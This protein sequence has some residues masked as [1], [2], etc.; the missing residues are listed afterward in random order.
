M[1]IGLAR[2][3]NLRLPANFDSPYRAHNIIDF[4][5]RWH[6]TLSRF[7]RNYLYIP[8]GGNRRGAIRQYVNLMVTMLLGGLWHG[9]GWGFILWGGLNGLYLVANHGFRHLR[10]APASNAPEGP[11]W[12]RELSRTFTFLC[13]LMSW[14]LFRSPNFERAG[15]VFRGLLGQGGTQFL[16]GL[17]AEWKMALLALTML[18]VC[19]YAPNTQQI[20]KPYEPVF[21]AVRAGATPLSFR[22]LTRWAVAFAGIALVVLT[23]LTRVSEF[24]YF[25][26]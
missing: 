24:L 16:A 3:F 19:R 14:V 26:F 2:M 9:A 12:V 20:L 23:M 25:Q 6:M 10:G 22:F 21:G 17:H 4:W 15:L 11:V 13:V 7:L 5:S 18:L 8:L 1:A